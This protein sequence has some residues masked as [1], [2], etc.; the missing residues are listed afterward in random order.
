MVLVNVT[1][2]LSDDKFKFTT[3]KIEVVEKSKCYDTTDE[4]SRKRR[5]RKDN[6]NKIQSNLKNVISSDK[7]SLSYHTICLEK[8]VDKNKV[9]LFKEL[10]LLVSTYKKSILNLENNLQK[11]IEHK[12]IKSWQKQ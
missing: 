9:Q 11:H 6:L 12:L 7:N 5:Y 8:D 2:F 1:V 10:T 4:N 3:K